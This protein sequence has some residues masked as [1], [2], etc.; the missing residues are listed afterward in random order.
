MS[1]NPRLDVVEA[2]EEFGWI[3]DEDNPL[4]LLRHGNAVW[5]V[6]NTSGDSSLTEP[7]GAV[8]DFPSDTSVELVVAGCLGASGQLVELIARAGR[9]NLALASAKRRAKRR[10]PHEREGLIFHL[11]RENKRVHEYVAIANDAAQVSHRSWE[12]AIEEAR[13]LRERNGELLARIDRLMKRLEHLSEYR[14]PPT[15]PNFTPMI[16]RLDP[17][18][19][20]T[21]WAVLHDPGDSSV[22]RVWTA[23]GWEMAWASTHEE[24]FCWPDA[25]TALAQARR[26]R[27]EEDDREPDVDGAGR[28]PES[29]RDAR[30]ETR[31]P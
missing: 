23:E 30:R 9:L 18:Y 24:T 6:S 3:G 15:A 11:E 12:S 1:W 2:L 16:V 5:G 7:G 10:E 20:G 22:R 4:G 28:T 26:A 17:A 13:K 29:Y 25:E 8:I 14:L 21:K 31:T 27:D 19:D